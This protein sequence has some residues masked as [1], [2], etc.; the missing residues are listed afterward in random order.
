MAYLSM[1]FRKLRL[2]GLAVVAFGAM[3][4]G[5][6]VAGEP[7]YDEEV[8]LGTDS[9][10][11]M[12]QVEVGTGNAIVLRFDQAVDEV[13]VGDSDVADILPLTDHSI[14]VL[15][16]EIGS[17][18]LTVL[19]SERQVVGTVNLLVTVDLL[20]IKM[21]LH[22]QYPYER[23]EVRSVGRSVMLSGQVTDSA[24][25]ATAADIANAYAPDQI[26]NAMVIRQPQQVM[27]AVRVAEIQ[28]TAAQSLGLS[29][30]ALF[31]A[32]DSTDGF[33]SDVVDTERTAQLL[34]GFSE[35]S[36]SVDIILDALEERGVAT[37]L[38]EPTLMALSGETASF[39]AGG[40]F[41]VPV[42]RRRSGTNN[43]SF[44]TEIEF[45]EFGVRLGF[46]PTVIGDT[47]NLV[48]EPE[49]SEIDRQN[50]VE[51]EGFVI[52]G[53]SSRRATTTVELGHGQSFAIAGL[54][55]E[56][57]ADDIG[58][59]PGLGRV[60][61]LGAIGRSTEFQRN[62]T[63]LVI[64]VTPYLVEPTTMA[65]LRDPVQ[66][67]VRPNGLEMF[68][69]GQTETSSGMSSAGTQTAM[70]HSGPHQQA[71]GL[72]GAVGYVLE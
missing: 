39:L 28:R 10:P 18:S 6:A 17:T 62:E 25:S 61:I 38:A 65:S 4:T 71:S 13:L 21:R 2:Y 59:V 53:I 35:A 34:L 48:V 27:L 54:I 46:T 67:F 33:F 31:D 15:G 30:D 56:R 51:I 37:V 55:S 9:S 24:V 64:I 5:T 20:P 16:R 49:V 72:D 41:P 29:L 23:I 7:G 32:G 68:F 52:P 42:G 40:E 43:E 36:F 57:F 14:Y 45:K 63:E 69:L 3:A 47:I 60:P 12:T 50:G 44:D 22:E 19:D 11:T 1:T 66:D 70:H 8:A 58:E 26:L